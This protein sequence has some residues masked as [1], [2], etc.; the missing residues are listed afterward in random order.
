[1]WLPD[2]VAIAGVL[3]RGFGGPAH[4]QLPDGLSGAMLHHT[5]EQLMACVG[6]SKAIDAAWRSYLRERYDV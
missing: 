1:L 6:K 4:C 2:L 5:V 3:V